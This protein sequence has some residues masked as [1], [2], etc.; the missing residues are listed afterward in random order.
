MRHSVVYSHLLRRSL[1]SNAGICSLAR[2]SNPS[3]LFS[4][5]VRSSQFSKIS[6]FLHRLKIGLRVP[7]YQAVN[8]KAKNVFAQ[9]GYIAFHSLYFPCTTSQLS[10]PI[11]VVHMY[12]ASG[13][14][15]HNSTLIGE[16]NSHVIL[17][18]VYL[19]T[20]QINSRSLQ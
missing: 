7:S 20:S 13:S 12:Y 8:H 5:F 2:L 11:N 6:H 15:C 10:L 16:H 4:V 1:F 3:S 17:I 9:R 18:T 19:Y 14:F